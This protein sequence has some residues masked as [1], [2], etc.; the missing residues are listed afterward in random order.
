MPLIVLVW[1]VRR[2]LQIVLADAGAGRGFFNGL[3]TTLD[4]IMALPSDRENGEASIVPH[5]C[6]GHMMVDKV[7]YSYSG[8][9]PDLKADKLQ[10][11]PGE[12]VAVIGAVG[13]GKSTLVKLLSGLFKPNSGAVFLDGVDMMSL[14]PGFIREHVG[15]L[16]QDVRLFGGTLRENITM[17]LPTPSDSDIMRA[18]SLT[19]LDQAI[20]QHPKGLELEIA[21]GGNGL[22][23]GQR[24]LVGLTRMLIARPK[25]LLLDE[26][27]A[28][29]DGDLEAKVAKHLF[30]DLPV[31]T[32]VIIVTHKMAVLKHVS[33]VILVDKGQVVMDGPRDAVMEQ[34]RRS[35]VT[36]AKGKPE[37]TGV[38]A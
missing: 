4:D 29:M 13:S 22:S 38:A 11:K 21:E 12:R 1:V 20:R 31:D 3:L 27:T 30:E 14:A 36:L 32:T 6:R 7:S 5:S 28:S 10:F 26:P 33:R 34:I 23:G 16:P 18:A 9:R 24:Q 25:I 17:G 15:Y 2:W 19:G 35:A 8:D 37:L